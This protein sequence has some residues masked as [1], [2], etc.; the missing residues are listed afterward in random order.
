MDFSFPKQYLDYKDTVIEFAQKELNDDIIKRDQEGI[1]SRNLWQKCA[2]FGIQGLAAPLEYGGSYEN[3]NL[4]RAV[5]AMEGL[6]YGCKDNGLTLALNAQMWTV[7]VIIA[8]FGTEAQKQ[9][10]LLPLAN[11]NWLG[12]HAL[13][14]EA[15]GSDTFNMQMTAQKMEG[16]YL[17]NGEKRLITLAPIADMAIVFANINPKLGR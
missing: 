4:T 17:L 13:T 7:Q 10:F 12:A 11:G 9:K 1:F 3:I 8:L 14:E 2:S 6:G 16:G 5:L 15:S